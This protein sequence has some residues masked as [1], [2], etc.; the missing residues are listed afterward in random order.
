MVLLKPQRSAPG[1]PFMKSIT[2]S[3]LTSCA[4]RVLR[5]PSPSATPSS[6]FSS[7]PSISSF[8]TSRPPTNFPLAYSC[9]NVGHFE[10]SFNP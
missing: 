6:P 5:S 4:R 8:T 2:G 1:A 3:L 7:S 9:G 10:S